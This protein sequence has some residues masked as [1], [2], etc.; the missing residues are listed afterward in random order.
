MPFL[1]LVL[2]KISSSE[3]C[4]KKEKIIKSLVVLSFF[5]VFYK[6]VEERLKCS[7]FSD[8]FQREWLLGKWSRQPGIMGTSSLSSSRNPLWLSSLPPFF[9]S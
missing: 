2:T 3:K 7:Y 8:A 1:S 4:H 5:A 9:L 6:D